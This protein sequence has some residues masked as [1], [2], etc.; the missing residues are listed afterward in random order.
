VTYDAVH[1]FKRTVELTRKMTPDQPVVLIVVA[2]EAVKQLEDELAVQRALYEVAI[3]QR[4]DAEAQRSE[5]RAR[6]EALDY[7]YEQL[8]IACQYWMTR[9]EKAEAELDA[10]RVGELEAVN[11]LEGTELELSRVAAERD[12]LKDEVRVRDNVI[13]GFKETTDALKAEVKTAT[14][15]ARHSLCGCDLCAKFRK[16]NFGGRSYLENRGA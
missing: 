2:E 1:D 9:A 15:M 4:N 7:D 10:A 8:N 11:V 6:A 12:A 13:E 14:E 16:E 5:F 3:T